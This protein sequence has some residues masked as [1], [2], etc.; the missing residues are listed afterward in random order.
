MFTLSQTSRCVVA[1]VFVARRT[2]VPRCRCKRACSGVATL[3]R[4]HLGIEQP[5]QGHAALGTSAVPDAERR[6]EDFADDGSDIPQSRQVQSEL[7][8]TWVAPGSAVYANPICSQL[9]QLLLKCEDLESVLALLVTHRGVFFV[10]NLV[11]A[12]QVLGGLAEEAGDPILVNRLL[13]DPR[14]DL[15]VRDLLRFVPKLDF[16]AMANV[17]C[18]L[19]QLDHKHYVLLS[20]MLEPLL[21]QTVPDVATLLRCVRAYSWAGYQQQHHFYAHCAAVLAEAAAD[22]PP[23][24]LVEACAVY[25]GAAHYHGRLFEAAERAL[26]ARDLLERELRPRE[27]ALLAAAFTAHRRPRHD[28]LLLAVAAALE[29]EAAT[30]EMVDVIHCLTAFRRVALRL[31]TVMQAGFAACIPPLHRGWLLRRR[32]DGIRPSH[33]A[34]LLDCASYFGIQTGVIRVALDYLTDYVD[35]LSDNAS[36]QVVHAMCL[37]GG[38]ATHSSMLPFLFRKVGAGTAWDKQKIRVFQLWVSQLLQFPWLDTRL[39]RRCIQQGLRAWCL[40]RQGYGSPFPDEVRSVSEE[41]SAMDVP[42]STFLPIPG[43]PYEVDIAVG[44]RKDALLVVSETSRNTF[45]PVG[46]ALLQVKHLEARGWRCVLIPR[47]LWRSLSGSSA[48][49]RRSYLN[50]LLA[51][52]CMRHPEDSQGVQTV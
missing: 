35:E 8:S 34:S 1:R 18:S 52:C 20:R 41:L 48:S 19:R 9:D 47:Q 24:Q 13:R 15:L 31:D 33:V 6:N 3:P 50:S 7:L 42:H 29:R 22:L 40:R 38:V 43:T 25:G 21:R 45:Q 28:G 16:L 51:A 26:L 11:T 5:T 44:K 2:N 10:H 14:Y 4:Q 32:V 49:A 46:G 39:P 17:A 30:M 27:A 36:I 37:T 23:G 12:I